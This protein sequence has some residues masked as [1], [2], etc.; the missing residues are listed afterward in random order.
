MQLIGFQFVIAIS[1][2]FKKTQAQSQGISITWW[3][4]I[5]LDQIQSLNMYGLDEAARNSVEITDKRLV[6]LQ[7]TKEEAYD[8]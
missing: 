3:D 8:Q 7:A 5:G 4:L 1:S 6:Q 2:P